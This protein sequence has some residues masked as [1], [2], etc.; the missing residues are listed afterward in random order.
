[1]KNPKK[2]PEGTSPLS[3]GTFIVTK[4][5]CHLLAWH[6]PTRKGVFVD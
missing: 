4:A 2:K 5:F 6:F 3:F 1:M